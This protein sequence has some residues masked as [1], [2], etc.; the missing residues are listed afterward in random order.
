MTAL[1][2]AAISGHLRTI[3]A[4]INAGASLDIQAIGWSR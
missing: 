4:L 2:H 1:H 3:R